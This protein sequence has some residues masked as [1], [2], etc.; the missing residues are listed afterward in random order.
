MCDLDT[1]RDA[2]AFVRKQ[3]G[4][5]KDLS[6]REF[7]KMSMAATVGMLLPPVSNA[8]A[9]TESDVRVETSDGNI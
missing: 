7:G 3:V 4:G 1:Q 5:G 9:V 8:Q 6:R 2:D